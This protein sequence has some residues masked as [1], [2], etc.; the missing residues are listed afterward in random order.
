MNAQRRKQIKAVKKTLQSAIETFKAECE[1][2]VDSLESIKD[3]ELEVYENLK[4]QDGP[5]GEASQEVMGRIEDLIEY[6]QDP[7]R[8]VEESVDGLME[9]L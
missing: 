2:A 6:L 7:A 8:D 5:R 4:N 9:A 1:A 3:E